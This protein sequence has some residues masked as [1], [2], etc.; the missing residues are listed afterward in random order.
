M[1]VERI[2]FLSFWIFFFL[3]LISMYFAMRNVVSIFQ[4]FY[5]FFAVWSAFVSGIVIG[6]GR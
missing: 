1:K 5:I 3:T 4:V 6:L 2:L